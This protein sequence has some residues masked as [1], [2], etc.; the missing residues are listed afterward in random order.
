MSPSPL[1]YDTVVQLISERFTLQ[2]RFIREDGSYEFRLDETPDMKEGF[3]SFYGE[4][5]KY[6][7]LAV[8]R[9]AER[10]IVVT[11]ARFPPP[12][13]RRFKFNLALLLF[14][15]T[16]V[17]VGI[18]GWLRNS[19]MLQFSVNQNVLLGTIIYVAAVLG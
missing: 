2:D 10:D 18:D 14:V 3:K 12:R 6:G 1:T 13:K 8:M 9:R 15:G 4:I 17:T 5:K 19:S 16:I 7:Y 11:V